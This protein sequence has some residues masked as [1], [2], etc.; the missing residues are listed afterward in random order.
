MHYDPERAEDLV[1]ALMYLTLHDEVRTWKSFDWDI[2]NRLYE[3][4][5]ISDPKSRAKSVILHEEG[6]ARSRAMFQKYLATAA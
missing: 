2:M 1:L 3:K 6:M 5:F 4:G